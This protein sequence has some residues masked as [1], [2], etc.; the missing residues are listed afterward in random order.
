MRWVLLAMLML[1]FGCGQHVAVDG[2]LG[3]GEARVAIPLGR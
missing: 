3:G 2:G 1:L